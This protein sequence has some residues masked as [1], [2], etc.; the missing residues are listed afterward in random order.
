VPA[1]LPFFFTRILIAIPANARAKS[2]IE[3]RMTAIIKFTIFRYRKA[4]PAIDLVKIIR[5]DVTD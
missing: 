1:N 3:N 2:T 5:G 4:I